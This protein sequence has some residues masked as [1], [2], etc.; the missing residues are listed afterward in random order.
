[1]EPAVY[2]SRL[3]AAMACAGR[4]RHAALLALHQA[5]LTAYVDAVMHITAEQAAKPVPVA[6]D[7][8]TLAQIVGHIA[9]W[10]RF[11]ILSAGDM[12]AGVVHPRAVKETNGYVD[13]DGTVLN[14]DDVDGFNAWAA[15]ADSRRTWAEIQASAVQAARTFYGLLAH[16]ELLSA[17]RL[18]QT[19]LHK[20]TLGDG[21][22]M[23]DLPMGW[24]LWLLQIEHIAV[25]HAAELGLD[26]AES[27]GHTGR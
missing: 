13:A 3:M 19:A 25:S 21:T 14:F 6:G 20:K 26:E 8:R 11:S 9:A 4:E 24:V 1:M 18:E 5:A 22:V 2:Q 23:E 12:L 15:D 10:D 16:D 7:A 17:D 27:S